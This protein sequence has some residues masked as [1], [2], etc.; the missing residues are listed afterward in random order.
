M[1]NESGIAALQR[2]YDAESAYLEGQAKDFAPVAATLHPD[3]VI[4]QPDSLPYAGQWRGHGGFH[5]WMDAFRDVFASLRVTDPVFYP[6]DAGIVFVRSTVN[7]IARTSGAELSWPLVQMVT[8]DD[9]LVREIQPF[10]WDT[11]K[12]LDELRSS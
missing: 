1:R 8:I 4:S 5:R 7:A 6:S 9:G 10:Y 11:A 2:F 12:L 3:C